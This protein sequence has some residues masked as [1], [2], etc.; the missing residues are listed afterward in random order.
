MDCISTTL[1]CLVTLFSSDRCVTNVT[2]IINSRKIAIKK[3]TEI[4][5]KVP[6]GTEVKSYRIFNKHL[7][8]YQNQLAKPEM[9]QPTSFSHSPTNPTRVVDLVKF[10][11]LSDN[12]ITIGDNENVKNK[13][14]F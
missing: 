9:Q 13:N 8:S 5:Q 4:F 3:G 7:F 2:S 11:L 14:T 1:D 10:D 12:P 6:K